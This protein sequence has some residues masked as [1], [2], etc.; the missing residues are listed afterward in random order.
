MPN[1]RV[2]CRVLCRELSLD[3]KHPV[4]PQVFLQVVL[5][6]GVALSILLLIV[7]PKLQRVLSGEQVVMSKL[8]DSRFSASKATFVESTVS[9]VVADNDNNNNSI[10]N[11]EGKVVVT[12]SQRRK[13][14][15]LN[16]PL[17]S[18]IEQDI[19]GVQNLL[20][21]VSKKL[22]VATM[23]ALAPLYRYLT[24]SAL[25]R[26]RRNVVKKER[27]SQKTTGNRCG[28]WSMI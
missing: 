22:Y 24:V 6:L 8:L 19:L 1:D 14:I 18:N 7:W 12:V 5:F 26:P 4:S 10:N 15:S 11:L 16:E 3:L 17:P 23:I 13:A 9:I 21:D 20:R 28:H 25:C 2:H 27:R